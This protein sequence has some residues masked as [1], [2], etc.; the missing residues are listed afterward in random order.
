MRTASPISTTWCG[1][2]LRHSFP[3]SSR[4]ASPPREGT[5]KRF[6]RGNFENRPRRPHHHFREI[7]GQTEAVIAP[8][9]PDLLSHVITTPATPAGA[10]CGS[11]LRFVGNRRLGLTH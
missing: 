11:V 1:M 3:I 10:I 6:S 2:P 7:M 5:A 8:E 4:E 9:L